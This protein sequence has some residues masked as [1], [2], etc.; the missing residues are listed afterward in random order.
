MRLI[1]LLAPP[2]VAVLTVVAMSRAGAAEDAGRLVQHAAF[3]SKYVA[4]RNVTVWLPPGYDA[5]RERYPVIY[6]HDGQN[7]F[8]LGC[9]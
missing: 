7:L 4:A 3:A 5:S 6:M 9:R 8:E 1:R 2:I